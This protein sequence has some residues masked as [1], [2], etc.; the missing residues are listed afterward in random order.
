MGWDDHSTIPA[1]DTIRNPNISP[2]E[3]SRPDVSQNADDDGRF[4]SSILL[5]CSVLFCSI[6]QVRTPLSDTD[7]DARGY[8]GI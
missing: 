6:P 2:T 8:M 1:P 7:T 3:L 5:F 4:R